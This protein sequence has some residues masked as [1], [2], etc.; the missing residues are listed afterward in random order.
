M[1]NNPLK[2]VDPSGMRVE[3]ENEGLVLGILDDMLEYGMGYEAGSPVDAM[4]KEWAGV[5]NTVHYGG[6]YLT[7]GR[8]FELVFHLA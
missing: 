6:R 7:I 8:T 5:L 4:I 3:F 2:Y 1:V